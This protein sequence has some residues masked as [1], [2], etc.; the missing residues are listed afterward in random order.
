M[1]DQNNPHFDKLYWFCVLVFITGFSYIVS[2]T[3]LAIPK[4]NQRIV[5]TATGFVLGSMIMSA[6]GYLLGGNPTGAKSAQNQ[7]AN[8]ENLDSMSKPPVEKQPED[9]DIKK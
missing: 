6:I 5:D 3:F 9:T 2:I 4:E 8:V 1:A 7:I